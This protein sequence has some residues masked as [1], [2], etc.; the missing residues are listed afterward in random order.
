ME[1]SEIRS[2][3]PLSQVLAY[4]GL[5][6]DKHLR[7]QCPF[8]EDKTPS[9]QV[10]YKTH[11]AYCFSSNC[12]TH[13]KSLD[14]IDFVMHQENCN[15][16]EALEKCK[17]LISGTAIKP[18]PVE[19]L[20]RTAILT[21]QF[22]YFKNAVHNSKPAQE[23]ITSRALDFTKLEIGYN[24]GQFHHGTRKD[25]A[26]IQSCIQVGLLSI[27]DRLSRTGETAYKPF[28]KYCLVFALRNNM[29]Q[30][31]GLYFRSTIN[32]SDQRHFYLK[33]REGLYPKYPA[34]ATAKL[35]LTESII[36]AATLLQVPAITQSYSVLALYGTNGLTPEHLQAMTTLSNPCEIILW[37]NADEAGEAATQKH[38]E[39]LRTL[40]KNLRI[41]KVSMPAGEDINSLAQTHHDEMIFTDLLNTRTDFSFCERS[42]LFSNGVREASLSTE[43]ALE[44]PKLFIN[45]SVEKQESVEKKKP[46]SLAE[47]AP[48]LDASNPYK[49]PY[50]TLTANYYVQGGLPKATDHMKIMLVIENIQTGFKARNRV[51]LYEDKQVEKLCKEVAEKLTL[52]K[53]LLEADLYKLTDLLDAERD[54]G[55]QQNTDTKPLQIL[56]AK[57]R[58]E[59][60]GFA[61][62][63]KLIKRLNELLNQVGIV[64]E[65]RNRIFL[66]LIAISHKMPE[67]LHALIQGSSGSGKTRLLKQISDCMPV[68]SVTKLTRLS[69]KVLYNFPESYFINRLLCLEDIDG[70][71]E[72]AEFAF[73]ELQSNGELNS[74]TS[75]KLDNGQITSGQK[76]VKGPIA[77]LACTTRGEIY[78]DNMSR[79]FLIAVDESAEQTRRIIEYQNQKA[80][81]EIDSRKETEIKT[82]VRNF[83][84]V[85]AP[86][87]VINPF[88]NQI[89]LPQEA[90]KIRRLND[91]F[92]SFVKMVTIINQYQRS[93]DERKRLITALEDVETAI[94][95][96]FESI[97]LK[98]DELDGSL[99]QFYEQLKKYL[100]TQYKSQYQT[101]TFTLREIRQALS[102]SKTQTFRYAND[103]VSLEYI[104]ACGGYHNKGFSYQISYWDNYQVLREKIK[105]RLEEQLKTLK[106]GTLRNASGTLEPA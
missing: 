31:S 87:E 102:L 3:L 63:P 12:K 17:E 95:I 35:I 68:E 37:L 100:Q 1:I 24:T 83:V 64:G 22:T 96:M 82:F 34:P 77:S 9:L 89:Q 75:I 5:K 66:L 47:P 86:Y 71:S 51:D 76:T 69:D 103:L 52:R 25:E 49:I 33:D 39:T 38:A 85:L 50:S 59:L 45:N 10:Y 81:G 23:Y 91:L 84:R 55:Q 61:K 80:A 104:R 54:K 15:K 72:E 57:E 2:R 79:V 67:T 44:Q 13:G 30:V 20:T 46:A 97:V 99:R 88:A 43:T 4:Y 21:K 92:Q 6:P 29:N 26:L 36:D 42:F 19:Q 65:E 60:E 32:D 105:L 48:G 70:L 78:E 90:H 7:L 28:A 98:V 27:N 8:H 101:A 74:A 94:H 18:S 53:D 93:Q 56:T 16:H 11:T 14:V 73:R 41:T 106:S 58:T 62:K 40:N